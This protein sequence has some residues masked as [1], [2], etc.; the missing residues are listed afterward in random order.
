[1]PDRCQ[2]RIRMGPVI[3]PLSLS[4]LV[5]TIDK[6]AFVLGFLLLIGRTMVIALPTLG[7]DNLLQE[8]SS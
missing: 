7:R 8:D 2:G 3:P 6:Q 5:E 1:M 4:S